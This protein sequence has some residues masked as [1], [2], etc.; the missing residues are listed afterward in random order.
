MSFVVTF[1]EPFV[2]ILLFI[3]VFVFCWFVKIMRLLEFNF[4]EENEKRSQVE[5]KSLSKQ[6]RYLSLVG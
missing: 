4:T 2:C 5:V 3:F 1:I 6:S